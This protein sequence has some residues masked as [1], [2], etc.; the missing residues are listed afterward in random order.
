MSARGRLSTV[1]SKRRKKELMTLGWREWVDLPELGLAS[2]KA[3]VDTG[4][5]TSALHAFEVRQFDADGRRRV[6]FRMHPRQKDNDTVVVCRAD[7]IDERVVRDSGGHTEKRWVIETPVTIG[8]ETWPI[9]ITLTA[10]DDMLFRM[11]LGR[12]AIR[13]R[14]VVDP[15][16]SYLVGKKPEE[17]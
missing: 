4:A 12:T 14:A 1:A 6:E 9:E 15:A 10:R 7:V 2:I 11:L 17:N 8:G 16:R 13:K 3:K 5:R